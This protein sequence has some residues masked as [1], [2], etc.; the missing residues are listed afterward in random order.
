[1]AQILA[2]WLS[3]NNKG[4]AGGIF[5]VWDGRKERLFV[6]FTNLRTSAIAVTDASL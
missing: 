3:R 2:A 1:M 6:G 4:Q 5:V